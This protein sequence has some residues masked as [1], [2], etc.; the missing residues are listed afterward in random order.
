ME[1]RLPL[2]ADEPRAPSLLLEVDSE[3]KA[4]AS[5]PL[6]FNHALGWFPPKGEREG[7]IQVVVRA[8]EDTRPLAGKNSLNKALVTMNVLALEPQFHRITHVSQNGFVPGRNFL[9]NLVDADAASRI[10]SLKFAGVSDE[11]SRFIKNTQSF[12][13]MTSGLLSLQ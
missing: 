4:G 11:V 5:F 12:L 9:N 13:V 8:P 2:G 10:Y 6:E 3:V 1:Y 7:D